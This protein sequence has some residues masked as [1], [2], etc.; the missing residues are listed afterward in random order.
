VKAFRRFAREERAAR[1]VDF[2]IPE[3]AEREVLLKISHCGICGSDLHAWLNHKGY[4]S[5]LPEV[6]FGHELSG[7][8]QKV[9]TNANEWKIGEQAVMIALQTPYDASD[10]YCRENTPQLSSRRRVQGLHLDGG[11][12]EYVC[13]DKEFLI[14]IPK[15]LSLKLAALTEPLSVAEHCIGNR[16]DIGDGSNVVVSGPGIIGLLCAISARHRGASVLLSGTERDEPT[17]LRAAR[18]IGFETLTVGPEKVNLDEQVLH[19]FAN[20]A[21]TLVEASGAAQALAESWKSVR[22]DGTVTAVA[23]YSRAIDMDLTQF[24]RKQIDLRTSYASSKDDYLRAFELLLSQEVD[25]D[26]LTNEYSL[27]D[28]EQGFLDSEALKVT[29]VLLNCSQT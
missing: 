2:P 8:V 7:T 11:M 16:T 3:P 24:L 12:A 22:P 25:L 28:A 5:V 14:P 9:G 27:E 4:E 18:K 13:I 15:D 19:H 21:D 29:K 20:G 6:T 1:L 17:R 10:R 23:L 26:V